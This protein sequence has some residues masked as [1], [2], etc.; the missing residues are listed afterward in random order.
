MSEEHGGRT[1]SD[2]EI[3]QAMRESERLVNTA[4]TLAENLPIGKDGVYYRLDKLEEQGLVK[5]ENLHQSGRVFYLPGIEG[6]GKAL[7]DAHRFYDEL[8]CIPVTEAE[9]DQ[10]TESHW[11]SLYDDISERQRYQLHLHLGLQ[12]AFV[13]EGFTEIARVIP[14]QPI[15]QEVS[16]YRLGRLC[17]EAMR[18]CLE[19]DDPTED[20][21]WKVVEA[22]LDRHFGDSSGEAD[23]NETE[24]A[25][26][27]DLREYASA[28]RA[29]NAS[30]SGEA[31]A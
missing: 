4:S 1:V 11:H 19:Q 22:F 24:T 15:F 28:A 12:A 21:R 18:E 10:L 16:Y 2:A 7:T 17:G 29:V 20:E 14:F 13:R 5:S 9:F 31:P 25:A 23:A 30:Q 8:A 27:G 3:M 26:Q 6:R